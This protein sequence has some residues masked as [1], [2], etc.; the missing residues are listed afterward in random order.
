MIFFIQTL[1]LTGV[2]QMRLPGLE[3]VFGWLR[4][5]P[6][7]PQLLAAIKRIEG[8]VDL[9]HD[10][11][12]NLPKDPQSSNLAT[13]VLPLKGDRAWSGSIASV[14]ADVP[15][16]MTWIGLGYQLSAKSPI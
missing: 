15:R 4:R 5:R 14:M 16:D 12:G 10:P 6:R 11:L 3:V 13:T 1:L 9:E 7:R 8:V 2:R